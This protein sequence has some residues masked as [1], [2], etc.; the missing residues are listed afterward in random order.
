MR[1]PTTAGAADAREE[2]PTSPSYSA[3][4]PYVSGVR[5]A[6]RPPE[7][8]LG[9]RALVSA[10]ASIAAGKLSEETSPAE[11]VALGGFAA[12]LPELFDPGVLRRLSFGRPGPEGAGE[13]EELMLVSPAR[14]HV[15]QRL[16]SDR[17]RAVVSVAKRGPS[18]G[19]I[20]AEARA[21][22]NRR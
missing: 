4:P 16:P 14:V 15:A 10:V 20:V 22:S 18:I 12:A 3:A 7:S 17:R 13:L 21:T 2:P 19:W 5:P 6:V 11:R 1:K 9:D 8:E